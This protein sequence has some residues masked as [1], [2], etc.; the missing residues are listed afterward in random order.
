M[1]NAAIWVLI[2]GDLVVIRPYIIERLSFSGSALTTR[3]VLRAQ[4]LRAFRLRF[5]TSPM[6]GLPKFS[7][8]VG[9]TGCNPTQCDAIAHPNPPPR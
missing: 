4:C 8:E 3:L 6:V 7:C 1:V 9:T 5:R 2:T